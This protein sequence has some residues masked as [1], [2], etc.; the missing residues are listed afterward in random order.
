MNETYH[1]IGLGGIGMSALA[2][3]LRQRGAEVK[4]SDAQPSPLLEQLQKEGI[5]VRIGHNA[6]EIVPGST[7]IYSTDIR[8]SNVELKKANELKL[9]L[10]HRSDLLDRL[11]QGKKSLLVTGTHGKTTTTALLASVLLESGFEP[12]FVIGGIL[13]SLNTNGK[14]GSGPYFVAE[15]DE[16]DGSFLKTPSFGAIVTNLENDH[17]NYWETEE[18]L[19]SAFGQFFRQARE[20]K[21]LFWCCDDPRL[22]ALNPPGN[23][24]GFSE[25]AA[26]RISSFQQTEKGISFDCAFQGKEYKTVELS[27]FGHHNALNG[28]AVFGLCLSLGVPE[29]SIRSAF[30][31]FTGTKRRLEFKGQTQKIALFDDYGHHPTEIAATLKALRGFARERRLIAV[32]QPHRFTRV[33]DLFHEFTA[34]FSDADVVV[35]TDIYGAGEVP[36]DGISSAALYARMREKMGSRLHFF[37]RAHLEAGVAQLVKPLDVVATLG[38]GDVTKAGDPILKLAAERAPKWT[39]GLLCGGT[40]AEHPVSLVSARKILENLDRSIYDVKL[41]GIT[42]EGN[43]IFG[44]DAIQKLEQKVQVSGEK[45]PPAILQELSKCEVVIPALHG[46]QSEDGMIMGLLDTL[47]IPYAGC[48]YRS[49]AICMQKGWSKQIALMHNVPTPAF[50]E[51]DAYSYRRDP[52]S[53]LKKIEEKLT[54][55]VWIKAV[56]LGSSLG[57]S[58]ADSAAEVAKCAEHAFHY[59]ETVIVEQHVDSRQVE[60]ALLGNESVRIAFPCE[61]LTNGAFLDFDLKYGKN[62]SPFQ[63]PPEIPETDLEVGKELA[64][65][66]YRILGCRGLSRIDFFYDRNGHFWFNE[67]NPFPGFTP[68]SAF[69]MMWEKSGLTRS[70]INDELVVLALHKN[71]RLMEIRGH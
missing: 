19:D 29:Q 5:G 31:S 54:Y 9:P 33:R 53:M 48:D 52:S 45:F 55:P 14:A 60:F 70:Q 49:S 56:H 67:I 69:P 50:F 21:H 25:K 41:F 40:S 10:L 68:T 17:L 37:P 43:W 61:V 11:M 30:R 47:Q 8:E 23:S 13:R 24:Y 1:L 59:D 46:P 22:S 12:S 16:S 34:C 15:A 2:R 4:G 71:R 36:I 58:R 57:I 64:K 18:R 63:I 28:A 44:D 42:K 65:T 62:A 7:V 3:I 51:M 35:L 6:E 32:F 20:P 38:A 27:L 66:V 26:L 39:L